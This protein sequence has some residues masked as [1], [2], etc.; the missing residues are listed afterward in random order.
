MPPTISVVI[1]AYNAEKW[2]SPTIKS[3]QQQTF[4]DLEIIVIDDGSTDSTLEILKGIVDERMKVFPY[5]HA[6][7]SVARNRGITHSAGKFIAFLD[8]DDL[9]TADCLELL[10]AA[11]EQH[12]Q[13]DVSY[14]WASMIDERGNFLRAWAEVFFE[15]NVYPQLLAKNFLVCGTLLIRQQT[16]ESVGE[17]DPCLTYNEDWDYWI[18]LARHS[19]FVLVP[20]DQLLYRRWSGGTTSRL[21]LLEQHER[22]RHIALEKVF[23]SAPIELQ[24]LKNQH[25]ANSYLNFAGRYINHHIKH[26]GL[27]TK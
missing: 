1:P 6:G 10:L 24:C 2:I 9:W 3:V 8:A 11:L 21:D 15:G 12:P 20:K 26:L 4:S 19:L 22:S 13:A 17:F 14:C 5:E 16:I 23:H 18:R 7:A 25:L 27:W